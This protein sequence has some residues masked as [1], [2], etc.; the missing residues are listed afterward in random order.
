MSKRRGKKR[1]K[2]E[3]EGFIDKLLVISFFYIVG[4]VISLIATG[5][6]DISVNA[7][8]KKLLEIFGK[9]TIETARIDKV[10]TMGKQHLKMDYAK[11][12]IKDSDIKGKVDIQGSKYKNCKKG[13]KGN[14]R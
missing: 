14:V 6:L 7:T 8:E 13:A 11:F 9:Y 3:K 5:I 10:V 4:F 2:Y 1:K 12:T